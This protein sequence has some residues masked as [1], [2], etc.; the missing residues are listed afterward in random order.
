MIDSQTMKKTLGRVASFYDKRKV[1]ETGALGFRRSSDLNILLDCVEVLLQEGLIIPGESRFL[2][3]GCAD[4]RVNVF[5]SYLVRLSVGIELDEWTAEEYEYLKGFLENELEVQGLPKLPT[6][7]SIFHGDSTGAE[8][9]RS[10][11]KETGVEFE[12]FDLFY[13]YLVMHE[14][15]AELIKAR[16][17]KGSV[18]LV[19]G[20]DRILPRY[21]GL[22]L[23]P[24]SPLKGILAA[25]RKE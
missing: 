17:R 21:E 23:L 9:Y 1:G 18:F 25:Y 20:V 6:N 2:D 12:D 11:S 4:G 13:T 3:L 22:R 7:I 14:E 16:G 19:Y 8:V 5:F 10:I 24:V 15:F